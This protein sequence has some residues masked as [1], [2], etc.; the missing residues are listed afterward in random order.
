VPEPPPR[1]QPPGSTPPPPPT[2][3]PA[4]ASLPEPAPA[5]RS[6]KRR[7]KPGQRT[8]WTYL[9]FLVIALIVLVAALQLVGNVFGDKTPAIGDHI[10]A[11]LVVNICGDVEDKA[12]EF[13]KRAGSEQSA[14]IHSHGD[15]LMHIHPEADDEVGSDATVG[16]FF[17]E[18][19][20]EVSE[21]RINL[22]N[23]W[24]FTDVTSGGT[25][26]D[27]R[28]ATVRFM[29]NGTEQ[30]GNPADYAPEDGDRIIIAFLPDGDAIVDELPAD[31]GSAL[32]S[33]L[34]GKSVDQQE[35]G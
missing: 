4:A 24:S 1:R 20:W 35:A 15:G 17:E 7:K 11:A 3:P 19:G 14:G 13:L 8:I 34:E 27:G 6:K 29:V 2:P 9:F 26:P 28:P 30:E 32:A 10:H 16:K 22:T 23:G 5:P 18:G 12:P 21:D 33:A 25:C 31:V